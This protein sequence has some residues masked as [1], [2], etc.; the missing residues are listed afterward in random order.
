MATAAIS[1]GTRARKL[2]NTKASTTRA[3]KAPA[4][5]STRTPVPAGS[6][7]AAVR[8]TSRPVTWTVVPA[9]RARRSPSASVRAR[10]GSP[11][12]GPWYGPQTSP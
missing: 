9:G 7:A 5:V 4:R 8:S 12:W 3:P 2:P 6:S 10:A 11:P 1:S